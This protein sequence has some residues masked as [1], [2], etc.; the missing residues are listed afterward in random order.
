TGERRPA[1]EPERRQSRGDEQEHPLD[2]QAAPDVA[3]DVM[4]ELVGQHGLDL[5]RS[6]AAQE[7]IEDDDPPRAPDADRRGVARRPLPR[8]TGDE[9]ADRA[10]MR[11]A[12]EREQPL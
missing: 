6:E 3:V 7:R 12:R 10:D 2:E 11:A 8:R 1:W 9:D 4:A 5:L